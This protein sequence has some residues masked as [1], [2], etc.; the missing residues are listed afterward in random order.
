MAEP[1]GFREF[2][3][4]N[5]RELLR[6]AWLLVGDWAMAE[7]L[8]QT[9]LVKV[10]P[11]WESIRDQRA[12]P[13]YVRRALVTTFIGWRRRRWTGELSTGDLGDSIASGDAYA[14]ADTR[15]SLRAA[16]Q[17]LSPRQRSVLVLRYFADLTEV[18]TA[19]ELGCSTGAVKGYA[20]RGLERLRSFP[21][22]SEVLQEGVGP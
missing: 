4:G 3:A 22:L 17:Q 13:S 7:D 5:S 1:E 12:A 14:A 10:L 20:A 9:T 15:E 6:T 8:V 18:Q 11:K 16:L 21:G 2:V 19:R